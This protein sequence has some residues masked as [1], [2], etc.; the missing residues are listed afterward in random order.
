M[1]TTKRSLLII[2]TLNEATTLPEVM[3]QCLTLL[4]G[5]D[6]LIVDDGSVDGTLELIAT[7]MVPKVIRYLILAT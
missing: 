2:P 7:R 5:W 3:H 1:E 6:L 4:K